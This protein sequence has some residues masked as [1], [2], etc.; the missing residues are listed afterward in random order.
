MFPIPTKIVLYCK[1]YLRSGNPALR[2]KW[3]AMHLKIEL[4]EN[5]YSIYASG[6]YANKPAG[7]KFFPKH[8]N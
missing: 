1:N 3:H 7:P 8:L 6:I 4:P 2:F 5:W